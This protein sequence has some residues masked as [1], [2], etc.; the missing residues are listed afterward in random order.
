MIKFHIN[1]RFDILTDFTTMVVNDITPSLIVTGEGGLGKTFII[2][3]TIQDSDLSKMILSFS[4]VIQRLE[5]FITH[6][7]TIMVN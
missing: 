4:K 5:D 7:M 6:F 2:K 3:K 1:K